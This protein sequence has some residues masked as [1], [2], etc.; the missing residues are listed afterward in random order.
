MYRSSDTTLCTDPQIPHYA[1]ILKYHTMHRSSDTTV[2]TDRQIPHY[3]QILRY[4]TM[5]RSSDTTLCTDPQVSHCT[6]RLR[7]HFIHIRRYHSIHIWRHHSICIRVLL[8]KLPLFS[9]SAY[10]PHQYSCKSAFFIKK[11]NT[12][13]LP[14]KVWEKIVYRWRA[15]PNNSLLNFVLFSENMARAKYF[16]FKL[17]CFMWWLLL[18]F[19]LWYIFPHNNNI[20]FII[21]F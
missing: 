15:H 14:W 2:C 17:Y 8:S 5:Y 13:I 11:N 20:H 3:V 19:F 9:I 21:F 16:S 18:L 1:Q 12:N 6:Q 7:H 10:F 4:H